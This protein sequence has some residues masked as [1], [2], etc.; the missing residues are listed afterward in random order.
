M[1]VTGYQ[2]KMFATFIWF[3]VFVVP[4]PAMCLLGVHIDHRKAF[5]TAVCA[6]AAVVALALVITCAT[7]RDADAA[8]AAPFFV[9]RIYF[10]LALV[11]QHRARHWLAAAQPMLVGV[12]M[13]GAGGQPLPLAMLA[14]AGILLLA[15]MIIVVDARTAVKDAIKTD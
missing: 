10:L 11:L 1:N 3:A 9:S 6:I 14:I 12:W 5:D 13:I 7:S 8:W 4:L 15:E 2:K